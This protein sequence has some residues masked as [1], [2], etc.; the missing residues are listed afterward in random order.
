MR[1]Q[2]V[3]WA[4]AAAAIATATSGLVRAQASGDEKA[5]AIVAEA[6][7]ALGGEKKLSS[8]KGL[9]LR[10]EYQRE[11][12]AMMRGGG[13]FVM[14]GGGSLS[15]SSQSSGNIEIDLELPDK[16]LR[17]DAGSSGFSMTRVEGFEGSRPF[18]DI[19]SNSAGARINFDQPSADPARAAAAMKRH[20][21]DVARLLLGLMAGVQPGFVVTYTYVGEA[22]SPDG[23][24]SVIDV[25]GPEDFKV[26][27]FI[28]TQTHLPLMLT[29]TE[30]E[31][32]LI[33]RTLTS[34]GSAARSGGPAPA[35][36]HGGA[37]G[38]APGGSGAVRQ[39]TPE[40]RA[41]IEKQM[42]EAE[43]TPPKMV[44]YRLFFSD[45]RE[46]DGI[47]LP[48]R[49]VRGTAEKTTEEWDVKTY[50]VNPTFKADRFAVGVK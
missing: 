25:T 4:M 49:I 36:G 2:F 32:R 29:Y 39:L 22:E 46:V 43:A 45:Y 50:K 8:V 23:K 11:A 10:A 16:Y 5:L 40:Q 41:E 37:S 44:D 1:K 28:D 26:R 42:K 35:A 47:S 14:M 30:A 13:T 20:Q 33:T 24:A 17:S 21:A 3:V 48:H 12:A 19:A 9:S 31:P 15:S 7:K 34:G 27:L 18:L 6:R 38:A